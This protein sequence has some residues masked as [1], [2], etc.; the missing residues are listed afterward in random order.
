MVQLLTADQAKSL[1]SETLEQKFKEFS[2]ALLSKETRQEILTR[3]EVCELLQINPSTL[4]TWQNQG[5]IT[6]YGIAGSRRYYKR[7]EILESLIPLKTK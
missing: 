7:S 6:A 1:F 5:K 2:K 3:D 4:W